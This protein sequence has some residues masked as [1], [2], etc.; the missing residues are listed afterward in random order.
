[1][2]AWGNRITNFCNGR[3]ARQL[4]IVSTG[5]AFD[6][7]DS[8]RNSILSDFIFFATVPAGDF[9]DLDRF[10]RRFSKR[11]LLAAGFT[12]GTFDSGR[13]L[14]FIDGIFFLTVRTGDLHIKK[15]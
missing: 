6:C 12:F 8:G 7:D 3:F 11:H 14:G 9:D 1:M 2:H 15:V 5:F 13:Q 10:G 4:D